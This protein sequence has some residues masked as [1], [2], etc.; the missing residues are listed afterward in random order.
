MQLEV[1]KKNAISVEGISSAKV[2]KL[3]AHQGNKNGKKPD[4]KNKKTD[5]KKE[6]K[7]CR[8]CGG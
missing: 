5:N 7:N 3:S 8:A 4:F 2:K 6:E 1:G